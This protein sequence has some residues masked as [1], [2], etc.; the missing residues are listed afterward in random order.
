MPAPVTVRA[1]E[2]PDLHLLGGWKLG[3]GAAGSS[4]G[5]GA[6]VEVWLTP[7]LHLSPPW[8]ATPRILAHLHE[9]QAL[10]AGVPRARGM[11]GYSLPLQSCPPHGTG[12]RYGSEAMTPVT[13]GLDGEGVGHLL[14]K[15]A[16]ARAVL[17]DPLGHRWPG[18]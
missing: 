3:H 4:L 16:L 10:R 1:Q 6:L 17:R 14:G 18:R 7:G 12:W 2:T 8:A 13:Q 9:R 15:G 11:L 5:P